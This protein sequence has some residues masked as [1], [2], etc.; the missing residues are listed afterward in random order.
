[1]ENSLIQSQ[2]A[3]IDL[4][5]CSTVEELMEVGPE[6]LKESLAAWGLQTGG[7]LQQ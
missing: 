2:E 3:V 7:T 6:K 5:Y 1:M 4:D